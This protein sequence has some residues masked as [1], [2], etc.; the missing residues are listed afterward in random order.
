[1]ADPIMLVCSIAGCSEEQARVALERTGGDAVAAIDSLM[2]QAVLPKGDSYI[3]KPSAAVR[4][5]ITEDEAYLNNLR[6]T[7]QA[8]DSEIQNVV[9]TSNQ[10]SDSPLTETQT[11]HEETVQQNSYEQRCLLPSVEEEAE[12]QETENQ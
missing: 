6:S 3:R 5:D 11:H 2:P 7:M 1:M 8:M 9:V 4:A 10:S 12:T